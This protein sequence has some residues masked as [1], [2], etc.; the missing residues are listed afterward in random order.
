MHLITFLKKHRDDWREVLSAPPYNII[1]KDGVGEY[2]GLILFKYSQFDSDLSRQVVKECRGIIVD[3]EDNFNIVCHPFNKFFNYGE[4]NAAK[5][6][7]NSARVQDKVDGSL[8]KLWY[9]NRKNMWVVSTNGAIDAFSIKCT[10]ISETYTDSISDTTFGNLFME[11]CKKNN[12]EFEK[13]N[14]DYNYM[15]ELVS[16]YTQIVVKY[17]EV[18]FYHLGT[19][20]NNTQKEIDIDIG[21]KKPISYPLHSLDAVLKAAEALNHDG[22]NE[23]NKEGFVVVDKYWHRVK[24]KSPLYLQSFY[25]KGNRLTFKRCL[26]IYMAN[27]MDEYLSYFPEQREAFDTLQKTIIAVEDLMTGGWKWVSSTCSLENRKEFFLRIANT[28]WRNYY[29]KKIDKPDITAHQFLF[30]GYK[31]KLKNGEEKDTP[32]MIGLCDKLKNYM[33]R[34]DEKERWSF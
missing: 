22:D 31:Y 1:I 23:I 2:Q 19:R 33:E 26:E 9:W 15:F 7:W 24:I 5:V 10:S 25:L 18:D 21:V 34:L 28:A 12:L 4:S 30:G 16:P 29:L 3:V 27:E 17:L 6:D 32:P 14:K 20:N 11:A 13:L 8:M